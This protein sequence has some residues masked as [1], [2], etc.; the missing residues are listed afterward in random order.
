MRNGAAP[1]LGFAYF[2]DDPALKLVNGSGPSGPDQVAVESATLERSGLQIGERDHRTGRR[3]AA[4]GDGDRRGALRRRPGRG[5]HRRAGRAERRGRV[6]AGRH[7]AVLH[8]DRRPAGVSDE[9]LRE[10][11]AA[12]LP[13]AAEAVT[14]ATVTRENREMIEEVLG[15]FNTFLLIFAAISLFV[16]GFIIVNTFSMLVAQRTRELALLRAVG[17]SRGQVL[18]VVLGRG[19]GGRPRRLGAGDR[20]RDRRGRAA[21]G[22]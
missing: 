9:A 7:R 17:A 1:T 11:L 20:R 6:R 10:R 15:F 5:H 18:R 19:G 8:R 13:A 16:G 4:T 22:S 3:R 12:V 2:P 14:A 21:R